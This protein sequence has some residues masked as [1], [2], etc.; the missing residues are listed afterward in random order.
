MNTFSKTAR[1]SLKYALLA[2]GALAGGPA[3]A[4]TA[5]APAP[6]VTQLQEVV[7]TAQKREQ[8]VQDVP[9][10]VTPLT[11]TLI[12]ANRIVDPR[13]LNAV[14]P[15]LTVQTQQGGEQAANYSMRGLLTSGAALGSDK[16]ISEYLDGVYLQNNSAAILQLAD[17]DRIEVLR[18]PQGTLF[19]RNATGG[20]IN[21]V[22]ANPP[23]RFDVHQEFT[24]GNYD[25]FRSKTRLDLPEIDGV[26]A[27]FTI[28]HSEREGDTK[29]LGAGT[30]WNYTAEGQGY[31]TS[32]SRLGDEDVNAFFG[33]LRFDLLANLDLIYKFDYSENAFTPEAVSPAYI[34]P[35][36]GGTSAYAAILGIQPPGALLSPIT[37][38]RPN[39]VNNSFTTPGYSY[40]YGHNLTAS[41]IFDHGVTVKNVFSW[42]RSGVQSSYQLDGMGGLTVGGTPFMFV[43]A[44]SQQVDKQW[45]DEFQLN[46]ANQWFNLTTGFLY[47]DYNVVG[48]FAGLQSVFEGA[49]FPNYVVPSVD[50][51]PTTVHTTSEGVYAQ[52]EGH[53]T[54]KLDIVGG[55]RLT[56]DQK[57]GVD[58]T[59]QD[60]S[61]NSVTVPIDYHD[62][63]PTYLIGLNYRPFEKILTYVKYS[64]GFISG[65]ELAGQAYKPE[66]AES[67]EAGIKADLLDRRLRSN[68]AVYDVDYRNLQLQI[69]G[70]NLTP[71]VNAS[72]VLVNAASARARGFE[73][74]NTLLVFRGL[75]LTGNAGYTD[76]NYNTVAPILNE[77]G[78]FLPLSRPNWTGSVSAE[79]DSEEV[80]RG[81]HWVFRLDANVRGKE[82]LSVTTPG[83]SDWKA[84]DALTVRDSWIVNGRFAL[85]GFH[86]DGAKAQVALWAKNI[87]NNRDLDLAT[88]FGAP[89][90][91]PS[92]GNLYSGSFERARTFG[93]DVIADF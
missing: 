72:V 21:I 82:R 70:P 12:Q 10:A 80:W 22:T 23:G 50:Y 38:Q 73:W 45:S 71:P 60:S 17:I 19:G 6:A 86:V 69:Y 16:G 46:W 41:Y 30:T 32:P 20:A 79:H 59:L 53:I 33:A 87:L 84:V 68:L 8:R 74:E 44:T 5:P 11:R 34:S 25:Q 48:G 58:N 92:L 36:P 37:T 7:V 78:Y 63:R 61:N 77:G 27:S 55:Y 47:F 62:T 26:M 3:L 31:K 4:Q 67:F 89:A 83:I 28:L 24:I 9:I 64:T 29:N 54:P 42:R 75:T 57:H 90:S 76:F 40:G 35:G 13:D 66:T 93:L 88:I 43:G 15:S 81:G 51:R 65:G 18:G 56:E 49:V 91:T 1:R 14:T 39:A 85:A 52:I 2:G